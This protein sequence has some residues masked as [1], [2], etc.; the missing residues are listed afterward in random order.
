MRK[1]FTVAT[2]TTA[3]ALL[4]V[5]LLGPGCQDDATNSPDGGVKI[6]PVSAMPIETGA[7]DDAHKQQ[8]QTMISDGLWFLLSQQE[9]NGGWR[10]ATPVGAA[11]TGMIVKALLQHPDFTT[12]TPAVKRG[13]DYI[14]SFRQD[15]GGVY[16]LKN[17]NFANYTSSIALMTFVA[18]R[19]EK[20]AQVTRE[21]IGYLKDRQ[22]VPGSKDPKGRIVGEGE[23]IVGG[24]SYGK[25]GRPDGSNA[26]MAAEALYQ[27]GLPAD[28]PTMQRLAGFFT[29]LQNRSESNTTVYAK[30]G[31]N[32][33]GFFY[34]LGESKAG[35]GPEG[36]GL[37]SYGTL[38]Y[39]GFKSMLYAGLTKDDPRV[40][41]AFQWIR[42]YWTLES[43]PNMPH[44]KT[45]MGLY[46]YYHT[47]AKALRA[48]GRPTVKDLDGVEHNWREELIDTLARRGKD[49]QWVNQADRWYEGDPVLVTA[50]TVLAIQEAARK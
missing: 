12:E 44:D 42:K 37:R 49:G 47:Y 30:E 4:A 35:V 46:Y 32:D 25:H 31:S 9:K 16:D 40:A 19:D 22:I 43:N 41:S 26:G 15:D 13:L 50:Y 20:Y 33:G 6:P 39:M 45:L 8:A 1:T 3:V 11:Y 10:T 38:T 24:M 23:D 48:W 7:M 36:K 27:A 5:M 14:L 17:P 29:R 34:A 21:L 18:T 2:V 28:D